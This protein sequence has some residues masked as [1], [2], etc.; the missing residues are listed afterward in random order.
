MC[1]KKNRENIP[2]SLLVFDVSSQPAIKNCQ[3]SLTA[4]TMYIIG[5]DAGKILRYVLARH[6]SEKILDQ[7]SYLMQPDWIAENQHVR[8]NFELLNSFETFFIVLKRQRANHF[9]N[10]LGQI[11]GD[12][13][14]GHLAGFQFGI[15]DG[16]CQRSDGVHSG[17][18]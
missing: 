16:V 17:R 4:H 6:K 8:W 7:G 5:Q 12:V 11:E 18:T 10:G 14:H 3:G 2:G 13:H 15:L 1:A 9:P